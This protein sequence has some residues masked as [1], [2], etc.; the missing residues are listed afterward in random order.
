M[1]FQQMQCFIEAA[2]CKNFTRAAQN[3]YISQPNLTKYIANMEKELGVKLFSRSSHHVELTTEGQSLLQK[4]ETVFRYLQ[5]AV[6]ETVA[7]GR[8]SV[9]SVNIGLSRD[10]ILPEGAAEAMR[11]MNLGGD[12]RIVV[13]QATY[14]ALFAG[15]AD[16]SYDL[17]FTTDRNILHRS[18]MEY[19]ALRPFSLV[20]AVSRSH[21]KASQT[22]LAPTDFTDEEVFIALPN[23]K[24]VPSDVVSSVF[25]MCGGALDLYFCDSPVDTLLNVRLRSGVAIVSE[26]VDQS[27]YPDIRFAPFDMRH[28]AFQYLAWRKDEQNRSV[29][30]CRDRILAACGKAALD[31]SSSS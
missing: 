14:L 28:D 19:I 3:L 1:T 29:L 17:I 6:D 31:T 24:T 23:G 2:H 18:D 4:S 5:R 30:A 10:E 16:R 27:R 12:L 15:L 21:P 7:E 11:D 9:R 20:L 13:E 22:R 25:S 8:T 26:L